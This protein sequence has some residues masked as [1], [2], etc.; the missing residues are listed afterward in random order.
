MSDLSQHCTQGISL[1]PETVHRD[2]A[3]GCK[4]PFQLTG[5][6][7][8]VQIRCYAHHC[9]VFPF[10]Y[11]DKP[12]SSQVSNHRGQFALKLR[13]CRPGVCCPKHVDIRQHNSIGVA[14]CEQQHHSVREPAVYL[15]HSELP[16][17]VGP[18]RARAVQV[19]VSSQCCR[20]EFPSLGAM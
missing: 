5:F 4:N 10:F 11:R 8:V 18:M 1:D 13:R 2:E 19:L 20:C 9:V 6:K 15:P 14:S 7:L 3:I 16:H 17:Y 12:R